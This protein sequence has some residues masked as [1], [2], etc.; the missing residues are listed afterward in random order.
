[1]ENTMRKE[2]CFMFCGIEKKKKPYTYQ[3]AIQ[4]ELDEIFNV[5][6]NNL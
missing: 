5:Q 2:Q 1:M 4:P 3:S 6:I